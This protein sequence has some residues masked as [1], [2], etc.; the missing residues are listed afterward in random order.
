MEWR[1]IMPQQ[2]L[3]GDQ[4]VLKWRKLTEVWSFIRNTVINVNYYFFFN[5]VIYVYRNN[6]YLLIHKKQY[7]KFYY[8]TKKLILQN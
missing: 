8:G 1:R 5:L 2:G 6:K 7:Q 4:E 3:K